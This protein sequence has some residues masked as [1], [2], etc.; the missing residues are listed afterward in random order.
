MPLCNVE[1]HDLS[2]CALLS[3]DPV[4][5][6]FLLP[7]SLSLCLCVLPGGSL[8]VSVTASSHLYVSDLFKSADWFWF[9][10]VFMAPGCV[11]Q[12]RN[13]AVSASRTSYFHSYL[14][15]E[16]SF[17]AV[18]MFRRSTC[19]RVEAF[20][21]SLKPHLSLSQSSAPSFTVDREE[22]SGLAFLPPRE[23]L[24]PYL[25]VQQSIRYPDGLNAVNR[26]VLW[27]NIPTTEISY[28]IRTMPCVNDN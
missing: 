21:S 10:H 26:H 1:W 7:T 24:W 25:Y 17:P 13:Y 22:D 19:S 9:P 2:V 18:T 4:F 12:A 27:W 5:A 14:Y 23:G 20:Y 6:S 3:S 15:L 11:S 16:P 28:N 8:S